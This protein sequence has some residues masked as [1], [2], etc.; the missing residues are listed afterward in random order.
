M[1]GVDRSDQLLSYYGFCHRTVK[2]W[3]RAFFHL[4]DLSV[5]NGYILYRRHGA[6]HCTHEQFRVELARELLLKSGL[7][8]PFQPRRRLSLPPPARLT[9]RH[10]L[11]KVPP[12]STGRP[13]QLECQ[14]CCWKKGRGR[15]T[16]TYRCKQCKIPLCVVPCYELYHTYVDPVRHLD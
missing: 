16:T 11:E 3:R 14:V 1:G 12:R 4:L 13:S 10:F 5:V 15:K 6:G 2:W 8:T 7:Q 9:E